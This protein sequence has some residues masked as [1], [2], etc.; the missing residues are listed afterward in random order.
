MSFYMWLFVVKKLA[1][2]YSEAVSTYMKMM[3]E[4]RLEL[5]QEFQDSGWN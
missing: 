5:Y 1:P 3:D 4:E 2:D